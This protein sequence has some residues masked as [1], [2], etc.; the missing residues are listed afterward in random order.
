ME[1]KLNQTV[2]FT[3]TLN[4]F[5]ISKERNEINILQLNISKKCNQSCIHCHVNAGPNRTEMMDSETLA[6]IPQVLAA[7]DLHTLDLTGGAPELL[8]RLDQASLQAQR[9]LT[10]PFLKETLGW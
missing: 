3:E 8:E 10:I 9:K 4:D 7:R 2:T 1:Y 6:L 5:E